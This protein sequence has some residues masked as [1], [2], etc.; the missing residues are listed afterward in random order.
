MGRAELLLCSAELGPQHPNAGRDGI[1]LPRREI[2]DP[3]GS[4]DQ[5]LGLRQF[6]FPERA[7]GL[8]EQIFHQVALGDREAATAA[9]T[10]SR[11]SHA[12]A[13]TG[14]SQHKAARQTGLL[15]RLIELC[16]ARALNLAAERF[17]RTG[18]QDLNRPA[19]HPEMGQKVVLHEIQ[20]VR[21][22]GLRPLQKPLELAGGYRAG[23]A[24]HLLDA[25]NKA[26]NLY[27]LHRNVVPAALFLRLEDLLRQAAE[28][29]PGHDRWI[30]LVRHEVS[31]LVQLIRRH[32]QYPERATVGY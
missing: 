6:V 21:A 10:V 16:A 19:T 7:P 23:D 8:A 28:P 14:L 3:A 4:F 5:D 12:A 24:E 31:L 11:S 20:V 27:D 22:D 32:D 30:I 15:G 1:A 13:W 17:L 25:V 18:R 29:L 9:T 26:L 2:P